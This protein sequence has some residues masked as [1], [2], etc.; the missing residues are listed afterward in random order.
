MYVLLTSFPL[1]SGVPTYSTYRAHD[2]TSPLLFP[3][4][5]IPFIINLTHLNGKKFNSYSQS[6]LLLTRN[7]QCYLEFLSSSHFLHLQIYL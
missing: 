6:L 4:P 2:L 3:P 5:F 7:L 1:S